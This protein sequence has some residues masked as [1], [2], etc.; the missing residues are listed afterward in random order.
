M[1]E[2]D[3]RNCI[4]QIEVLEDA[5]IIFN[6][7]LL[8]QKGYSQCVEYLLYINEP[9]YSIKKY[10]DNHNITLLLHK[11]VGNIFFVLYNTIKDLYNKYFKTTLFNIN[12]YNIATEDYEEIINILYY[13]EH[14]FNGDKFLKNE[15]KEESK[16]DLMNDFK[17]YCTNLAT[18]KDLKETENNINGNINDI[19]TDILSIKNIIENCEIVRGKSNNLKNK[20]NKDKSNSFYLNWKSSE[21]S[22]VL[23]DCYDIGTVTIESIKYLINGEGDCYNKYGMKLKTNCSYIDFVRIMC[24]YNLNLQPNYYNILANFIVDDTGKKPS[25]NAIRTDVSK[26]K[27]QKTKKDKGTN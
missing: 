2:D 11:K 21:L 3:Y 4:N 17:K 5:S 18:K 9:L 23:I 27:K 8:H 16:K 26:I 15:Y 1:L 13:L 19:G 7:F 25:S 22:K 24:K 14:L 10:T 12:N 6:D 20:T